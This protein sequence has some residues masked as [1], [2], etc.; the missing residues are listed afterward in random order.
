MRPDKSLTPFEIRLYKHYRVVHGCR[1]ALAFVLTFVLVRLL[2]IPEGTWPLITLVVVMGP[3]SFWGNVVPRAFERIGGTVLGSA[4]GLIALKLELISF[5]VML[6]WCAVAMFL[7]GWLALGKKPYQALLIGITLA[8]VVGAPAGDM[9]TALWRS[10]DVIL[11]SLLAMLFTGIWPQRAFLHWRIQMANYVTAFNRVYQAGFS[12]NLIERPRL[13]K[14]LQKILNDVDK[15]RGLITPASKET[16]IQKA[17]FEAIQT[18]SRNLVCMLELQINAHWASRPSHLLML[19]AHTLK[20]TQQMT[21]QTLLTIA[22]ALYEGNPQPIRANSERLNEIVAE[23]KQLMNERQGDNVAET[24][25][26]GYVWLSMELARQLELLSQLICRA[27]R[28]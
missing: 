27:L 20:E 7:C 22:H 12:P 18:V 28:K 8:V 23:L 4:L 15:M 21:Q 6:L 11:G 13:E 9:T 10:G 19:N 16:H 14:H 17:I 2:D 5:P 1:I 24:P 26:H 25:I 3:I